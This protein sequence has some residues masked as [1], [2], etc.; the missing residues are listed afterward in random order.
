MNILIFLRYRRTTILNDE[1]LAK[2]GGETY[3]YRHSGML[4]PRQNQ[5]IEILR[6]TVPSPTVA[7]LAQQL[8]VAVTTAAEHLTALE[9]KG[10]I[11]RAPGKSRNIQLTGAHRPRSGIGVA[12]PVLGAIAAGYPENAVEQSGEELAI[13]PEVLGVSANAELFALRVRGDSMVNAGILDG[14]TAILE[15]KR[16]P[17]HRDVVAALIDG[18]TTLKRFLIQRGKPFLR[19][20][21]PKYPDLIPARELTIQGVFRAVISTARR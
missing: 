19:A 18:E 13:S 20:E 10:V 3:P 17:A 12:I 4:S 8:G 21:N 16:E 9:R 14:D 1:A 5:I 2:I 7:E 6:T 11:R 15:A